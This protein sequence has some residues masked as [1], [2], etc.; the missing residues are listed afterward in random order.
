MG[1]ALRALF[2]GAG[3]ADLRVT[4]S[5]W[6]YAT[7]DDTIAWG[8]SYADRLLTSPMGEHPVAYGYVS[9]SDVEAMA[10]AFRAWARHPDA[11]W[12]FTHVE[13]LGRKPGAV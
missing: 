1:R 13:A 8:D 9:R 10:A 4:A 6:C 11:F 5:V 2:Q 7:A 3:I 12:V